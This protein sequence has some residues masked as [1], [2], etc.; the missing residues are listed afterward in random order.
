MT[1]SRCWLL[2]L[3]LLGAAPVWANTPATAAVE[4]HHYDTKSIARL[5]SGDSDGSADIDTNLLLFKA[6]ADAPPVR[7]MPLARTDWM[8]AQGLPVCS[9]NRVKNK[10]RD[11]K[12]LFSLPVNFYLGYQ[13]YQHAN[14]DP[15][16]ASLLNGKNQIRSLKQLMQHYP[17]NQIVIPKAYSFG[18][19]LDQAVAEIPARQITAISTSHY[20]QH[21]VA[22]FEAGRAD[23]ILLYPTEIQ[24]HLQMTPALQVRH[25]P[26]AQ[27]QQYT[28]G[29][30]MCADTLQTREFVRRVDTALRKLYRDPLFVEANS[31]TLAAA[32]AAQIRRAIRAQAAAK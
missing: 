11:A 22:M 14:T 31:R 13:L 28:T 21:F 1:L 24:A 27:A 9:L 12:F 18:D 25:Y 20:Y 23:F 29:H 10:T 8:M 30:L 16:P 26:L 5:N 2:L 15:L 32:E 17:H 19:A 7:E 6:L 3:L 4:L